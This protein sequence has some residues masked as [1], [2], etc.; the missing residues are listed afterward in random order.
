MINVG[1][2][3]KNSKI[4]IDGDPYVLTEVN[5][6]KPGK[7]QAFYK[8]KMRNMLTG[9]LL[10]KTFRSGESF[11]EASMNERKMQFSYQQDDEY[12][13]MDL[14]T[15]EQVMLTEEQI[16]D[17]KDFLIDNIEADILFWGERPISITLPNFVELEVTE[18]A[19]WAKGDSVAGDTKPVTVQTGIT[20]Q[21][22]PFIE[23]GEMIQVDTRT[24][25]YVTRV[26]K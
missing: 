2:L 8:C 26:K 14:G 23:E 6:V 10:D 22:P 20:L 12:Y 9:Q 24:G 17:A 15:Y 7:G 19:P 25:Q 11:E 5:F 1:D 13:F 4:L 21:V 18:A 3:R 16:G